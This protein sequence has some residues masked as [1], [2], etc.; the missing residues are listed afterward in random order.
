MKKFLNGLGH[1]GKGIGIAAAGGL[2]AYVTQNGIDGTALVALPP[3]AKL[4]ISVAAPMIAALLKRSPL[5]AKKIE[6]LK[7][8][9]AALKN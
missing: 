5:D 8:E 6:K 7:A 9:N 3:V 2:A 1:V 4:A